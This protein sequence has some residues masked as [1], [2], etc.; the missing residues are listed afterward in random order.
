MRWFDHLG[1]YIVTNAVQPVCGL[2]R[3]GPNFSEAGSIGSADGTG[4]YNF[5]L[6]SQIEPQ[7]VH[8]ALED[9]S[10]VKALEEELEQFG[11]NQ[12]CTLVLVLTGRK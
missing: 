9:P 1:P 3:F 5:A 10:W 2:V 7:D 6:L 11:K 12:V 8:E 4:V